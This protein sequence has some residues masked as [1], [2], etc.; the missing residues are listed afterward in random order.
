MPASRVQ[1]WA[2]LN[3][4]LSIARGLPFVWHTGC[5][6]RRRSAFD[7][8]QPRLVVGSSGSITHLP[9][10]AQ[11]TLNQAG[12]VLLRYPHGFFLQFV[13]K[14]IPWF[15]ISCVGKNLLGRDEQARGKVLRFG[16]LVNKLPENGAN[17]VERVL[18]DCQTPGE[19]HDL[20]FVMIVLPIAEAYARFPEIAPGSS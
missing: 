17:E 1:R 5:K 14:V 20:P 16:A 19:V 7:I 9:E 12:N 3:A 11:D 8:S 15:D 13:G 10:F 4:A 2:V 6:A 18:D